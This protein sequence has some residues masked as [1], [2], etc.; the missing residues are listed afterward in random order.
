[1][2]D[3]EDRE[4]EHYVWQHKHE[5]LRKIR[6]GMLKEKGRTKST[7][8][9]K[10]RRD[11]ARQADQLPEVEVVLPTEEEIKDEEEKDETPK[12]ENIKIEDDPEII[13]ANKQINEIRL[14][15]RRVEEKIKLEQ[16]KEKLTLAKADRQKTEELVED[17]KAFKRL[18]K[19]QRKFIELLKNKLES[20]I[21]RNPNYYPDATCLECEGKFL[22][23]VG[24]R[25]VKC[26]VCGND[27][28]L[29]D[30]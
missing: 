22:W 2:E 30:S 4:M 16:E 18:I 11:A 28:K 14:Q 8:W 17:N 10:P 20:L 6:S 25:W 26:Y 24:G 12:D 1:M 19:D 13:E 21:K 3:D 9:I 7:K 23:R 27:Y 5:P 29:R 15:R